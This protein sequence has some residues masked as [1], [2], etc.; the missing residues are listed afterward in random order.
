MGIYCFDARV[1]RDLKPGEYCDFP[2]L[3]KRLISDKRKVA[4][5]PF[6]GYWLDM[7]RPDDYAT[8]IDEFETRRNEFLP[9]EATP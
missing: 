4:S 8:A 1:L 5:H 6:E 7:G 9:Q 3:I 2:D